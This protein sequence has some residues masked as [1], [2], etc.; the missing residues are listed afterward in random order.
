MVPQ[1]TKE[2]TYGPF[3]NKEQ[4]QTF[5][6]VNWPHFEA[7]VNTVTLNALTIDQDDHASNSGTN[8]L[9]KPP[10]GLEATRPYSAPRCD[11]ARPDD[12]AGV[13]GRWRRLVCFMDYRYVF[14]KHSDNDNF[15]SNRRDLFG[16]IKLLMMYICALIKARWYPKRSIQRKTLLRYFHTYS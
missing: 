3:F 16:E 8:G 7:C 1:Y 5:P 11:R 10:M 13:E 9:I 4:G 2:N 15:S 6:N 14:S 12:W